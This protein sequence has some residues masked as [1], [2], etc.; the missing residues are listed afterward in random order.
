MVSAFAPGRLELIG[1]HTDYNEGFVIAFAVNLGVTIRGEPR[2]DGT[3][4][5][6]SP[7]FG[8]DSFSIQNLQKDVRTPWSNHIKGVLFELQ[9]VGAPL[10]GFE[11]DIMTTLP[12]GAGM[13]SSAAVQVAT[14]LFAQKLFGFS[15]GDLADPAVKMSM[16]LICS[17]A[18][19][20]FVGVRCGIM[21][22]AASL[23]GKKDAAVFLDCRFNSAE[24]L[25]LPPE[26]CFVVCHTGV[27]HMLIS[28]KYNARR[29]ECDEAVRLLQLNHHPIKTLR[30]I[31]S[32]KLREHSGLFLP[33]VFQRAM[34]VASENERVLQAREAMMRRDVTTLGRLMYESHE[35]SRQAFEN[36]TQF[37]DMLVDIAKTLPVC[38]G[39]R[40]TGGGFGGAT[41]NMVR[42]DCAEGFM[43]ELISQ[44]RL[45][46][47]K[48]PQ[49]FIVEASPGA[50]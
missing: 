15:F 26:M 18:E 44:Y 25:P 3:V 6:R 39:A 42:R 40:L 28:S 20:D 21:D 50:A 30:D 48:E 31:T 41:I 34:H 49:A 47:G 19:N 5:L 11:A 27:K 4:V 9:K 23:L 10:N 13:G 14:L 12:V 7:E 17:K 38:V 36:S 16:A 22:P 33:R 1:N 2:D 46:S 32:L 43:N 45:K 35:S 29:S 8:Q 37:L 24:N